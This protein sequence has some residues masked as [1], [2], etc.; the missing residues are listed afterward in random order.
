M[1]WIYKL[2]EA[3]RRTDTASGFVFQPNR[4]ATAFQAIDAATRL[5]LEF[6]TGRRLVLNKVLGWSRTG[7]WAVLEADTGS[8]LPIGRGDPKKVA[9]GERLIVFNVESN[10][11]VIGGVDIAGRRTVP[12]FGE[13][14]QI[15]PAVTA[16][17]AGGPLLD[18]YGR[19]VGILGGSLSPGA[20]FSGRALSVSP[21][22]WNSVS[23]ENAVTPVSEIPRDLMGSG[24]TLDAL[25]SEGILSAPITPMR[26]FLYGGASN[27]LPKRA[28]DP[29]PRDMSDFSTRDPQVWIIS[30][31]ARKGKL[32]KGELSAKVYDPLNRS[33]VVVAAKKVTLQ[34]MPVRI[35]F[36]FSP[37]SLQPGIYR[38]DLNWDGRPVWRT[39]IRITE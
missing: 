1:V 28:S 11:R 18:T 35:G 6:A 25:A 26:E 37:T 20:R 3:G 27:E 36:S 14:I 15:S 21:A 2:D 9:V 39:F 38:I 34:D 12:G 24:K 7:D 19:A 32:A 5:E 29:M 16:E 23:A 33:R 30:L 10:A 31:W 13:R 8:L 22:L 4:V 17:A